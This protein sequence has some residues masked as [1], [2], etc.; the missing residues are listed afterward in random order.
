[1]LIAARKE[2]LILMHYNLVHINTQ[3]WCVATLMH[4]SSDVCQE[5]LRVSSGAWYVVL[6]VSRLEFTI[7]YTYK[8]PSPFLTGKDA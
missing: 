7:S 5:F 6:S 4:G 1:M 8:I 3:L 2:L